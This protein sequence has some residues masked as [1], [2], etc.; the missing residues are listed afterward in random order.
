MCRCI[1]SNT[2]ILSELISLRAEQAALLGY[3]THAHY[4][5][6]IRM[7]KS[8]DTVAP[9]LQG[10]SDKLTPLAQEEMAYWREL[11]AEEARESG[12]DK[13]ATAEKQV[14]TP[15]DVRYLTRL[16]ELKKYKVDDQKI[17][18]SE[19]TRT[20]QRCACLAA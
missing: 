5:L 3:K 19:Q 12:E 13:E 11:K 14:I 4:V 15:A 1:D 16:S 9:F 17:K 6:E 10:L 2:P 7:A 20:E 18:V 8:P